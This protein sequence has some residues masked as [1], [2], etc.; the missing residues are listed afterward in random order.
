MAKI[1]PSCL[2]CIHYNNDLTCLA[3]PIRIPLPI[4]HGMVDHITSQKGDDGIV[5][6]PIEVREGDEIVL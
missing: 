5:W 4:Q 1:I 2:N 3:Y 6:S